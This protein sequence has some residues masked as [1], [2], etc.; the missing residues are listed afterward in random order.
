MLTL[1]MARSVLHVES[2][3][4]FSQIPPV[5]HEDKS[6]GPGNQRLVL[7]VLLQHSQHNSIP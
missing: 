4:C 2:W 7:S 3:N 5:C 1:E 6:S